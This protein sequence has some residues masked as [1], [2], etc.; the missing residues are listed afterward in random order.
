MNSV[1][2][3]RTKRGDLWDKAKAF[4]DEH[5]DG[6]GM[7]DAE[8]VQTYE[9]MEQEIV[10]M[11]EAID[12]LERAEQMEREIE[13]P[14]G[15]ALKN[16][17]EHGENGSGMRGSE[18]YLKAFW[19]RMRGKNNG[20]RDALEEGTG[21]E[22][23]YLVPD[24]FEKKLVEGLNEKNRFRK[25]CTVIYTD[26][27]SHKIPVIASK[28]SAVW[29]DEEEAYTE[30][31]D[32]FTQVTLTPHKLGTLMKVSEELLQDSVFDLANYIANEYSYRIGAAE[33]NAFINGNGSAKPTGLLNA[34]GG[35]GSAVTTAANNAMTADELM[36]LIYGLKG[37]YRKN[38]KL[39][40]N[41]STVKAIRKLKDGQGQYLWHPGL[42][43]GEDD[44]LLNYPIVTSSFMP[45]IGSGTKPVAFGDFS[46]YWIAEQQGRTFQ[47]L[48]ELYAANGQIGFKGME[49][50]DG[51]LVL[52]EAVKV[53]TMHA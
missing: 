42:L 1:L 25:M 53:I 11:G 35:A 37:Q 39:L 29:L 12:R 47:R 46:Y 15:N 16:R 28:G 31:D 49:R 2:E 38:A 26:S 48:N 7:M 8:S 45:E 33:E 3:L 9:R 32:A 22:G 30:G 5:Q 10:K 13:A 41:D 17:P 51:K 36:D 52:P 40:M 43:N 27:G 34:T 4:L 21:S 23:G 19:D 6:R 20:L 14:C 50:V 24:S 18:R 44:R